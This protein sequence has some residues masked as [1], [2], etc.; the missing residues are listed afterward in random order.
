MAIEKIDYKKCISCHRCYDICPMDVFGLVGNNVYLAYPGD[1]A[2][3]FLCDRICP[4]K[5]IDMD[6]KPVIPLPDPFRNQI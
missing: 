6:A 5:A 3:C 1:C 2:R 4:T